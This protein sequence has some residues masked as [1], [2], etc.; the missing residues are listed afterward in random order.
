MKFVADSEQVFCHSALGHKPR[1]FEYNDNALDSDTKSG[2]LIMKENLKHTEKDALR[3]PY[4]INDGD[5]WTAIEFDCSMGMDDLK[6][7]NKDEVRDIVASRTYSSRKTGSFDEDS[8]FVMDKGVKECELPE[9]TVCYKESIY[10]VVKDICIDEGVPSQEKIL[11]ESGSDEKTV[12][13]DLPLEKDQTKESVKEK[14][15]IKMSTPDGLQISAENDSNKDS[16]NQCDSKDLMQTREGATDSIATNFS[17]EIFLP[18]NKL[19]V[20]DMGTYTSHFKSSNNDSNNVEQQPFQVST[21]KAILASP[22]LVSAAE[23]SNDS[24]GDS[25]LANT[26]LVYA[27]KEPK[28]CTGDPMLATPALVSSAEESKNN[29]EDEMLASPTHVSSSGESGNG[30]PVNELVYN[31]KVENGSITFD[32]DSLAPAA[33]SREERLAIGD[34]ECLETQITSKLEEGIPDAHTV[35]RQLQRG[36]GETSFSAVGHGEESFSAVGRPLGSLINYS[37]QVAYSGSVSLRSD[38]STTSTRSFAFPILQSEWNSSPVRMA[39][40]ERRH[41]RKC[42]N[43]GQSL[44]CCRF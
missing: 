21:E 18:G 2:N 36:Q 22:A 20:L 40:A 23:E 16:A 17:E 28:I 6:N 19:P 25:M 37:G 29:S 30:S 33:S 1:P 41:F 15:D 11:F 39:K 4:A 14:E 34:S 12:C 43:W 32:F 10:H 38:S 27:T 26:T 31:S 13:I 24:S 9:L 8:D 3:L 5:G 35:S 7:E 44:L 42:R